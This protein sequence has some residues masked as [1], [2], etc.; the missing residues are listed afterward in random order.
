M[1]KQLFYELFRETNKTKWET[2][3]VLMKYFTKKSQ[4]NILNATTEAENHIKQF[5]VFVN[6]EINDSDNLKTESL[7]KS[8]TSESITFFNEHYLIVEEIRDKIYSEISDT[9]FEIL[10]AKLFYCYFNADSYN[11]SP[12]SGDGG[13]D[14]SIISQLNNHPLF[15]LEIYGQAKRWKNNINR[16]EIDGFYGAPFNDSLKIKNIHFLVF[17]T[18]SSFTS[19]ALEYAKSKNIIC[20]DGAQISKMIFDNNKIDCLNDRIDEVINE[21]VL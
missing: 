15:V 12:P 10:C 14:F 20:M 6:Q 2:I 3:E 11:V 21:L 18:T 5:I 8:N 7:F 17:V 16:P 13:Y 1:D 4:L 19:G 9:Q